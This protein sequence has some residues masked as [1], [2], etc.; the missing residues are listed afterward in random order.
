MSYCPS[1]M[2]EKERFGI[3]ETCIERR[4]KVHI[5]SEEVVQEKIKEETKKKKK[6]IFQ[7]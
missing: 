2:Q 5:H 6:D 7:V 3:C 1:C 4:D